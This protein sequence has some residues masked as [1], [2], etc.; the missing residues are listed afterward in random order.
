MRYVIRVFLLG[1]T[2]I[3]LLNFESAFAQDSTS[4]STPDTASF[5]MHLPLG[6][7]IFLTSD[8]SFPVNRHDYTSI[9]GGYGIELRVYRGFLGLVRGIGDDGGLTSE[10]IFL[11]YI[12]IYG[13][14]SIYKYYRF[15]VGG[16]WATDNYSV[17]YTFFFLG[18]SGRYASIVF[19]EPEFRIMFPLS[20]TLPYPS[21]SNS[22]QWPPEIIYAT[23]HYGFRDLFFGFSLKA[24]LGYN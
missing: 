18:A 14:M 6:W 2:I 13:G 19:I 1:A 4:Q 20:S 10:D 15:E 16:I 23:R 9:R 7:D 3:W 24:G 21:P 11:N 17:N 22:Y 8:F 5:K 12:S